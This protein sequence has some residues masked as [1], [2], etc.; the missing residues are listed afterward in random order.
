MDSKELSFKMGKRL[1]EE[2]ERKGL[3]HV[4]LSN[5]LYERYGVRIAKDS[6]INYEVC[7]ENHA[8][9]FKNNGMRVEYLRYLADFYGVSTDWLVGLSNV[10]N[11]NP[12]VRSICEVLGLTESSVG[13]LREWIIENKDFFGVGKALNAFLTEGEFIWAMTDMNLLLRQLNGLNT[14]IDTSEERIERKAE[15]TMD[16]VRKFI[17]EIDDAKMRAGYHR[18]EAIDHFTA[19]LDNL[20]GY[21]EAEVRSNQA[22]QKVRTKF[23]EMFEKEDQ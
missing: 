5:A 10:R 15:P 4:G 9:S 6:L 8:K 1:K 2:R 23:V 16:S 21:R 12:S 14:I 7:V 11:P 18:F 17:G 13:V 3:S 22:L 20:S 19:A